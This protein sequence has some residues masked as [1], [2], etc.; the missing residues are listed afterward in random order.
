M[1]NTKLEVHTHVHE[2]ILAARMASTIPPCVV[3][4]FGRQCEM[5]TGVTMVTMTGGHVPGYYGVL[6]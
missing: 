5:R 4:W 3:G 6:G 1:L 2:R